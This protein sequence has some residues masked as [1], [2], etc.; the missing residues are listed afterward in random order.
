MAPGGGLVSFELNHNEYGIPQSAMMHPIDIQ[1][2]PSEYGI[3]DHYSL[4]K[5]IYRV[6][7]SPTIITLTKH[8]ET[9]LVS[10]LIILHRKLMFI[11]DNS[12][13]CSYI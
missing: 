1:F 3:L 4:V 2:Q 9:N 7:L 13:T 8:N 5:E 12:N 6:Q 11:R 10:L